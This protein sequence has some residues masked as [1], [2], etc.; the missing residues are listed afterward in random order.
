[1]SPGKVL[2]VQVIGRV[3]V[4][5]QRPSREAE[6]MLAREVHTW[7]RLKIAVLVA[8]LA[9]LSDRRFLGLVQMALPVS[10]LDLVRITNMTQIE[11]LLGKQDCR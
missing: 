4:T 8:L 9:S 1:M 11:T 3:I 10:T 6:Q 5:W 7:C 2:S